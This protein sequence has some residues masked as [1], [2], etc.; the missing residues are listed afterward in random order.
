MKA[1]T[2]NAF[3]DSTEVPGIGTAGSCRAARCALVADLVAG[4]ENEGI[5]QNMQNGM[6]QKE[7]E[8]AWP[9]KVSWAT[10]VNQ[11]PSRQSKHGAA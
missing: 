7:K 9:T 10:L 3:R 4:C 2:F 1:F 11:G 6:R 5:E 8:A